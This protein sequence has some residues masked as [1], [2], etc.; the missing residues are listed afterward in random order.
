MLRSPLFVHH[1]DYVRTQLIYSLL[2]DDEPSTLYVVS[3]F[4]LVDGQQDELAFEMMNKEGI[5]PRCLEL[6]KQD[7]HD[8]PRLHGQLLKLLYEMS[9]MQKLSPSELGMVND[10]FVENLFGI[11]EELSDD[12]N[13]P[14]HYTVIR[15]LVRTCG[16]FAIA[17]MLT[18]RPACSQ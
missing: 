6:V 3:S 4:L 2:Q 8:N 18:I 16:D 1:K 10:A 9:R 13:D 11:V 17:H 7:R 5:F 14:Y 15:V 12:T